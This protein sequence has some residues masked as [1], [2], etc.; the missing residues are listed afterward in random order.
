MDIK[1]NSNRIEWV[2]TAKGIGLLLVMLGHLPTPY[3]DTWIYTF[4]MPLFFF[5]SGFV[6]SGQKYSFKDF[7]IKRIKSLVIPYFTLG[8]VIYL[9]YVIVNAIIGPENGLY[10]SNMDMLC[11]FLVQKHFW[12]VWFLACLFIVEIIYYWISALF[13]KFRGISTVVSLCICV[14]GLSLYHFGC[15]GLPWN[16]DVALVAQ[17]FFHAGFK[18]RKAEKLRSFLFNLSKAKY[19]LTILGLLVVNIGA[20]ALCI[21]LA[22]ESLDMS[23]GLYGNEPLTFISAFAGIMMIIMVANKI[24]SRFFSYLGRNTMILFSWHS[25]IVIVLCGYIYKY[26]GIFQGGGLA[27]DS[28]NTIVTLAII[29]AVLIPVNELIKKSRFHAIFG[30]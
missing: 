25:R 19:I 18:L 20:G 10:G 9:F 17:F 4:H 14:I 24:H 30:V 12:T 15:D 16:I 1:A 28:L 8:A 23:V 6:F 7:L 21:K 13:S 2:D 3:L 22:R 29:L 5:L 26:F 27:E 11:N